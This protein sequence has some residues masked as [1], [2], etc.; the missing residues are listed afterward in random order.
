VVQPDGSLA[1][2]TLLPLALSYDHRLVDGAQAA[3]FITELR[4]LLENFPADWVKI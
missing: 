4:A 1:P 2:R 3:R